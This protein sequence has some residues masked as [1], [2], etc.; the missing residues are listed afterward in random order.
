MLTFEVPMPPLAVLLDFDGVLADTANIH[1]AAWQRTFR[2]MGWN[3]SDESCARAA[4]ID[5]RAFVAEVFARRKLEAGDIEGWAQRKQE[6]TAQLLTEGDRVVAGVADLVRT[7]HGRTRF[8]VVSTAWRANIVGVLDRAKLLDAFEFLIAK[9]DVR[10]TKPDPECYLL[11]LERL[12]L[13]AND[14]VVVEDSASGIAAANAAGLRV[15]AVG[16][17]EKSRSKSSASVE[18]TIIDRRDSQSLAAALGLID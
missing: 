4:E 13:T 14:V 15:V 8:V 1:V 9:E 17:V 18:G 7:W 12:G 5:D 11:A 10:A 6:L 16:V 3:E 2:V